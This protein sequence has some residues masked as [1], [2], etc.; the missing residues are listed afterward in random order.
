MPNGKDKLAHPFL[1]T[2]RH[3]FPDSIDKSEIEFEIDTLSGARSMNGTIYFPDDDVVD[4]A[5]IRIRESLGN[6]Y[7]KTHSNGEYTV[8]QDVFFVGFPLGLSL[9][10]PGMN[11]DFPLPL[12]KKA[13]L[14]GFDEDGDL[15]IFDG[16]NNKGFSGGPVGYYDH[17]KSET[18][19]IA[20]ISGYYPQIGFVNVDDHSYEYAENS[21]IFIAYSFRSALAIMEELNEEGLLA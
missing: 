20:V 19:I 13:C 18:H 16:H 14:S 10:I 4:I 5:V 9:K 11:G 21:G 17:D 6:T 15:Y 8:G 12:T 1:I 3:L 2:A 7:Y